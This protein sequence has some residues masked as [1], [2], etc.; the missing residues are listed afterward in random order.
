M[1]HSKLLY[2][3]YES[4]YF[5]LVYEN[6]ILQNMFL[7]IINDTYAVVKEEVTT[8]PAEFNMAD[9]FSTGVNNVKGS[10]GIQDR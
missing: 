3:E 4:T 9:F 10:L 8:K 1:L 5:Q 2:I 7:A 6:L